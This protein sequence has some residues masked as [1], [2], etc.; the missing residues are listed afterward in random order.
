L[1]I[2]RANKSLK[3]GDVDLHAKFLIQ[4]LSNLSVEE[5]IAYERIFDNFYIRAYRHDIIDVANLI[6]GGLGDSGVKDFLAWLIGQGQNIY[7]N[8]ITDPEFLVDIVPLDAH[9]SITAENLGYAADLAYQKKTNSEDSLPYI[10]PDETGS[11]GENLLGGLNGQEFERR[12]KEL[13]PKTWA[14]FGW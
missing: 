7:K 1:G 9:E 14:K 13:Y 3:Q 6:Y 4:E 8:T 5:I 11:M 2:N 12:A 10:P